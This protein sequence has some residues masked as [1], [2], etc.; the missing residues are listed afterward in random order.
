MMRLVLLTALVMVAFAANSVLTRAGVRGAGLDV[1]AFGM[2]R[3]GAGALVLL[4]LC[5]ATGRRV[6]FFTTRRG[7]SVIGLAAYIIGF[8]DAYLGMESGLGALL[9]FGMVQVTMFA[10]AVLMREPLPVLRVAGAVVALAGLVYLVWPW[11]DISD[12]PRSVAMMCVAGLGWG[13]YSLA[14]R[15]SADPLADTAANFL[16]AAIVI[17]GVWLLLA[18]SVMSAGE[19]MQGGRGV[20]LAV[21]SGAVTSGLGYALWYKVLP[22]LGASVAAVAQLTVPPIA[23][24]GGVL[25]LGEALTAKF[26][27]AAVVI[28][29]GVALSVMGPKLR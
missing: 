3:V 16:L 7:V 1:A 21:V 18:G 27:L 2:I 13:L 4:V 19:V 9:L 20:W 22:G 26:A 25:F 5:L 6:A 8:T 10:G 28:L 11:S 12:D 24:L 29:G 17:P 14:G 15:G 23:A